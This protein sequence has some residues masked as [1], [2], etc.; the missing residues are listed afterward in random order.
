MANTKPGAPAEAEIFRQLQILG[1]TER[2][3]GDEGEK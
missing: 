3:F 2:Q 1:Q